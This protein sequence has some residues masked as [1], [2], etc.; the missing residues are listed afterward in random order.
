MMASQFFT[1]IEAEAKA[2]NEDE[3]PPKRGFLEQL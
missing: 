2:S 3:P 1:A